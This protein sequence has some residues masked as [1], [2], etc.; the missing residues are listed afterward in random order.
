M[1][2]NGGFTLIEL[3]LGV[4]ISVLIFLAAGSVMALLFKTDVKTKRLESLEQTKNDLHSEF[5]TSIKWGG[6]IAFTNGE[7]QVDVN[8]FKLL[9]GRIYKNNDPLTSSD[10]SI[11]KFAVENYSN[12]SDVKSY[13]ITVDMENKNFSTIKDSMKTVVSQRKTV[14]EDQ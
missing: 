11:T 9:D 1:K 2:K 7:L 6:S 5:T 3:L 13:E 14:F 4:T 12:T 8:T 10:I